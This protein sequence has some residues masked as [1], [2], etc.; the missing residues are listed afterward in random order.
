MY[1]DD[2]KSMCDLS[3]SRIIS[4]VWMTRQHTIDVAGQ[5]LMMRRGRL[6][7]ICDPAGEMICKPPLC[8]HTRFLCVMRINAGP[9]VHPTMRTYPRISPRI[10]R[11]RDFA[12]DCAREIDRR[13]TLFRRDRISREDN[14]IFL[15]RSRA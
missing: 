14:N 13:T 7:S 8:I 3:L 15:N 9:F 4:L 10:S 2:E 6:A 1:I 11:A 12:T 5:L